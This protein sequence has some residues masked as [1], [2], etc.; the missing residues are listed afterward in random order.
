MKKT[1]LI[2]SALMISF[3][4][5]SQSDAKKAINPKLNHKTS[6]YQRNKQIPEPINYTP[7]GS[8]LRTKVQPKVSSTCGTAVPFTTAPN[9][10]AVGGGSNTEVQNC[11]NYN[12]D[13]NAVLFTTRVSNAWK[14]SA[15]LTSGAIQSTW[16]YLGSGKWDSTIIY[17]DASTGKLGGR[18]P[19]GAFLNHAGDTSVANAFAVGSGPITDGS[20]WV[21]EWYNAKALSGGESVLHTIPGFNQFVSHV[22]TG[23]FGQVS[24]GALNVDMQQLDGGST[25]LV[26][27]ALSD[28]KY[29]GSTTVNG[30]WGTVIARASLSGDA[31]PYTVTWSADSIKPNFYTSPNYSATLGYGNIGEAARIAFGPDGKTGY[32]VFIGRSATTYSN[33][34]DSSWHPMV[35]KSTDGGLT[36]ASTGMDGYDWFCKHPECNRNVHT[37]A[38]SSNYVNINKR[39]FNF[40]TNNGMD[41]TVDAKNVL[42]LVCTLTPP[43]IYPDSLGY[44]FDYDYSYGQ[45]Y[46]YPSGITYS[47]TPNSNPIIWDFTTDGTY[48]NT[49][50]VDSLLSGAVANTGDATKDTTY[51]HSAFTDASSSYLPVN[52]HIT[53]SRSTDGSTVF[54]GWADSNPN[55]NVNY[56][57]NNIPDVYIKG[58]NVYNFR[59]TSHCNATNLGTC[60]YPYLA[61]ESYW[62]NTQNAWV[63][64]MVW[65]VGSVQTAQTPQITYNGGSPMN[66]YYNN[67][68]VY[69]ADSFAVFPKYYTANASG[70]GSIEGIQNHTNNAFASSISNYPNPFSN[71]TTIAVTLTENKPV[72]VK[73]YNTMGALV[74]TKNIDGTVGTNNVTFD[75][76]QVSSGVYYYT[77]TAGAEQATKKMVI[78]K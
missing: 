63:V 28:P 44:G 59:M 51:T 52:A 41:V 27:G 2:G 30:T 53:V 37:F 6:V 73:V 25:V 43:H 4:G 77:V 12:K 54:Y 10:F 11:L 70:C 35:Y 67:C 69:P 18:Y 47:A 15:S 21:A 23:R 57:W 33:S 64:P 50:I 45:A 46:Q 76:G 19:G 42:H 48:W 5:Y 71:T 55:N 58:Y 14:T 49:M 38:D 66:F 20:N 29:Q 24:G 56:Y 16:Q 72:S 68:G 26:A 40:S 8:G 39:G 22:D 61:P 74:F 78:Q 75:G 60:F 9:C 13:L 31:P 3:A 62:D 7:T 32:A 17:A 1:L 34:A 65:G 36:W